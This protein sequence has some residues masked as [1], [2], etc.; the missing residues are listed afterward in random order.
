MSQ[1]VGVRVVAGVLTVEVNRRETKKGVEVNREGD[2]KWKWRS[3]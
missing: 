1:L 3:R 2:G